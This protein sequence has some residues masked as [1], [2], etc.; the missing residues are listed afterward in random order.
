MLVPSPKK[1]VPA[2]RFPLVVGHGLGNWL[3]GMV[4]LG[5]ALVFP[6]RQSA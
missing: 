2:G 5:H 3:A 6:G 4:F 1:L